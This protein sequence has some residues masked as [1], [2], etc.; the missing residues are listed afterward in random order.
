[1]GAALP[2]NK[3]RYVASM[4]VANACCSAKAWCVPARQPTAYIIVLESVPAASD[5]EL[6]KFIITEHCSG[7]SVTIGGCD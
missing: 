7:S 5:V 2:N 4:R 1:M 3:A 6:R